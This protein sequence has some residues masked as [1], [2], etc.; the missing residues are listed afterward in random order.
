MNAKFKSKSPAR[1]LDDFLA[2]QQA[3]EMHKLRKM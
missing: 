2:D 3:Y 1:T